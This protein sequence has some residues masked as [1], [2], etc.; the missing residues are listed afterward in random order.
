[1]IQ[2]LSILQK[3]AFFEPGLLDNSCITIFHSYSSEIVSV[4][5][6]QVKLDAFL[7][8]HIF[9]TLQLSLQPFWFHGN[10]PRLTFSYMTEF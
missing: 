2:V 7:T 9:Q 6:L 1:M 5:N 8:W 3:R 10:F 4:F